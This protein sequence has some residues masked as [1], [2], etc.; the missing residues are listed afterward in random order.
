MALDGF[1][2]LQTSVAN[3]IS[4]DDLTAQIPDFITLAE[5]RIGNDLRV[6]A[7]EKRSQMVTISG[8]EYYGLPA[9]YVQAR[10]IKVATTSPHDLE[11]RTPESIDLLNTQKLANGTGVPYYYTIAGNELRVLP[12]PDAVYTIE[13]LF[14]AT[15]DPLSTSQASNLVY[16]KYPNIYIYACLIEAATYVRD[17][18]AA[19][20]WGVMYGQAVQAAQTA[21]SKDRHSGGALRVVGEHIGY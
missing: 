17:V 6:R 21:D 1:A 15:P 13:L 7:M 4:R 12:R 19:K 10:H 16:E 11:Y 20:G 18:E 9:G 8:E 3:W 2:N 5:V 14:Y